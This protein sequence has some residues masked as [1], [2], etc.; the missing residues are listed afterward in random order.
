[1]ERFQQCVRPKHIIEAPAS[2]FDKCDDLMEFYIMRRNYEK[3][4]RCLKQALKEMVLIEVKDK[5]I[6]NIMPRMVLLIAPNPA[7][8]LTPEDD[9]T[10]ASRFLV[11]GI[12]DDGT[13]F[14]VEWYDDEKYE[15]IL[16][17]KKNGERAFKVFPG[18]QPK[19]Q[20]HQFDE[21]E[22][23]HVDLD[24]VSISPQDNETA[25]DAI[26]CIKT[27]VWGKE[28]WMD[29]LDQSYAQVGNKVLDYYY[30]HDG[31]LKT[32]LKDTHQLVE[33]F[34][35]RRLYKNTREYE[36][37]MKVWSLWSDKRV[38]KSAVYDPSRPI[39]SKGGDVFN[40]FTGWGVEPTEP[41]DPTN[42]CPHILRHFKEVL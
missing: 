4:G 5:Y 29:A 13:A 27:V 20:Q 6:S 28:M 1:M 38:Y 24:G 3:G 12:K 40:L 9:R 30:D 25:D 8:H 33:E 42:P 2:I 41:Q 7:Y 34:K 18:E 37:P 36:N 31:I 23:P 14:E 16:K 17:Y 10:Y 21:D 22:D 35:Q 11:L 26:D 32:E 39:L 15:S 19:Q